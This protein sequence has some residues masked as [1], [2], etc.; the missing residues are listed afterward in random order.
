MC[1]V[2]SGRILAVRC[3][4]FVMFTAVAGC[5]QAVVFCQIE[6]AKE[7]LLAKLYSGISAQADA[8]IDGL[9]QEDGEVRQQRERF[10]QQN[11]ALKK[12]QRQLSMQ[13]AKVAIEGGPDPGTHARPAQQQR[14]NAAPCRKLPL[15]PWPEVR[16]T[17]SLCPP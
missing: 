11:D 5:V 14:K 1:R 6:R 2:P 17:A 7:T 12:L 13:E 10:M 3:D 16:A 8:G 9:L 15:I 4:R